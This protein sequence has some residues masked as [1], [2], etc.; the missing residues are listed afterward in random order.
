[1][2]SSGCRGGSWH[3]AGS[4]GPGG[5][6][7]GSSRAGYITIDIAARYLARYDQLNQRLFALV[8]RT[9]MA[10]T[11]V[12]KIEFRSVEVTFR[13]VEEAT[14]S[15]SVRRVRRDHLWGLTLFLLQVRL[16]LGVGVGVGVGLV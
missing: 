2:A 7:G 15:L 4:D 16:G 10:L 5:S 1:M 14:Q 8:T 12:T 9:L 11:G 3:Q 6:I 13:A